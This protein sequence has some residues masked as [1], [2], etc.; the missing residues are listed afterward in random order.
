MEVFK[1]ISADGHV[2]VKIA[3]SDV[4]Y[5]WM[6]FKARIGESAISYCDYTASRHG[7][8]FLPN[9]PMGS[10]LLVPLSEEPDTEWKGYHPVIFE[11]NTYSFTLRFTGVE[12]CPTVIHP[13]KQIQDCFNYFDSEEI[14]FISGSLDFI[15]EPGIFAL[16]YK[17]KPI[18]QPERCDT[19]SFLVVSPKLDTKNDFEHILN[20]INNEYDN[21]VYKY[22]TK[23]FHNFQ[24]GGTDH[25]D[26]IWLS[27]FQS[28]V[29]DYIKAVE[30]IVN[31]PN[32]REL[33]EIRYSRADRI[34]FWSL[35]LAEKYAQI[36]SQGRLDNTLFRH[37]VANSTL[38]TLENRFVKYTIESIGKRLTSVINQLLEQYDEKMISA[39]YRA[40]LESF[41][42]SIAKLAQTPFF[43]NLGRFEGFKQESLVLQKRTGYAQVY[44][45]W[46]ILQ[47][48]LELHQGTTQIGIRPI[49]E[50]YELWCFLKMKQLIAEILG[51]DLEADSVADFIKEDKKSML[52]PFKEN[53]IEHTIFFDKDGNHVELHY[54][55]TYN[56]TS[57]DKVHTATTEQR[58]DIVLNVKEGDFT[59]T[60]LYDAKYRV[61]DDANANDMDSTADDYA[62][63]PPSD[64]INQMHRYRDAIYYGSSQY[65]HTSKEIIGGYILFP[66][67]CTD[68]KIKERYFYKSIETVNIGAFPLLP[69]SQHPEQEGKL[70]REHLT[71]VIL[72][73]TKYQQIEKSIPQKG[74]QYYHE[75]KDNQDVVLVGIYHRAKGQLEQ[76]L[77]NKLYHV[78]AGFKSGSL[79]LSA[80]FDSAKYLLLHCEKEYH[81]YELNGNGPRIAS[82]QDLIKKGFNTASPDSYYLCYD[83]KS[84]AELSLDDLGISVAKI[85]DT[86]EPYFTLVS[87]LTR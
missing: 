49:W 59:L 63:Y 30:F 31:R 50:L 57:N 53:N 24:R 58:P 13:N 18:G 33:R 84:E 56:R 27:I 28:V 21:L 42:K 81:V 34:K 7:M 29:A 76:I 1:Y 74:L 77:K 47:S 79:E 4:T 23:T 44:R 19:L 15:N 62:D 86:A 72:G 75:A 38:D 73:K 78:R 16:R 32:M 2:E 68:K 12:G 61:L 11:T 43:R 64:A 6:R 60:Y 87:K 25:N 54:Q 20:A 66:G 14:K 37:E 10:T 65:E 22:L 46:F 48:G 3:T 8:L 52:E 45:Y 35:T 69:D 9:I 85:K 82:G 40:E 67:R 26:L 41:K 51:I 71:D 5:S 36:E 70:L 83:L 39:E 17:Y 55:H 80:G